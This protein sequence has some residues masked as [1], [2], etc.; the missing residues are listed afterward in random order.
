MTPLLTYSAC[1]VQQ[2]VLAQQTSPR[3][4]LQGAASWQI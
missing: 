1:T 3:V 4:P 2:V